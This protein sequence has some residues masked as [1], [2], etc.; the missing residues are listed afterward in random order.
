MRVLLQ[1]VRQASVE[2]QGQVVGHIQKGLLAFVCIEQGDDE[3]AV[4]KLATKTMKLRIFA[5]DQGKMNLSA[6]DV[7]AQILVVSQFTLAADCLSGNRPSF[8]QAARP[9]VATPLIEKFEQMLRLEGLQ[10]EQGV[11]G[12][13]MLVKIENDGPAT[14][15]LTYEPSSNN[16]AG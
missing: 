5:D 7:G 4:Q 12:A 1:R 2:V 15:W 13:D 11:F 10:V 14:F 8:S 6:L 3:V 9:D 16:V